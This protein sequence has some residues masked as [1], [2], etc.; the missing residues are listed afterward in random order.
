MEMYFITI[1]PELFSG[2]LETGMLGMAAKKSAAAYHVVNLRDFAVDGH[3]TVDDYLYGGGA[4]MVMMVQPIVEAVESI[5]DE[6]EK[7]A[8]PV[9]LLSPAGK[10]FSQARACELAGERKIIFVCGRYKGVD[11][12]INDLV[13]T[14]RIS[15]GDYI[16][17]GGELPA[18]VVADTVVRNLAGVIGDQRSR[19]TDSFSGDREFSLDAAYYTRPPL[20]RG[21]AVPEILLS[22][23]HAKI[24]EW[25]KQS[26]KE[27]TH[28]YRP[29]LVSDAAKKGAEEIN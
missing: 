17:S 12:R 29:D 21:H 25:R 19:D 28:L 6:S 26:A 4:G 20:Y 11:E 9:I 22:G 27:R 1:F 8:T 3:G 13:I 14:E 15:I 23:N 24:E 10:P 16:L 18:L 5:R 7:S 2:V